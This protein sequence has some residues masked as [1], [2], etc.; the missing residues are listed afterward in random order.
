MTAPK[1]TIDTNI[2]FYYIDKTIF[3]R[4]QGAINIINKLSKDDCV[5]TLQ[6]LA[7]FYYATVRKKLLS[8]KI[9]HNIVKDWQNVFPVVA[10]KTTTLTKAIQLTNDHQITFWDSMLL[11]TAQEVGVNL[12]L[13]ENFNHH[14]IID[15]IRIVNPFQKSEYWQA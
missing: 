9:A 15:G 8:P 13:S 5:L 12:L 10:A 7:E 3:A 14:Q 11:S 1:I 2:L 6:S 4:H